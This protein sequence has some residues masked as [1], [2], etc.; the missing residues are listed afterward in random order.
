MC[1]SSYWSLLL[2]HLGLSSSL[3]FVRDRALHWLCMRSRPGKPINLQLA[4]YGR[5]PSECFSVKLWPRRRITVVFCLHSRIHL[6]TNKRWLRTVETLA[7]TIIKL[8]CSERR[9]FVIDSFGRSAY[10]SGRYI[11]KLPMKIL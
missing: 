6:T 2:L 3:C 10:Y 5:D 11:T 1:T 8:P 9:N 4:L 7:E